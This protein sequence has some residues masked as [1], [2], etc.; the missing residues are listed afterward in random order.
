M[1]VHVGIALGT[2]TDLAMESAGVTLVKGD[3][4]GIVR[5]RKLSRLTMANIKQNL[6]FTFI[7][8]FLGVPV[9]AGVLSPFFDPA[10]PDHRRSGHE[11][12]FSLGCR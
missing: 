9:A 3:L 2:G 6:F 5:A 7:Y 10:Q 12:E 4:T 8:N 1:Q 11:F